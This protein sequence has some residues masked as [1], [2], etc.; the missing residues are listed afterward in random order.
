MLRI[1][2]GGKARLN[3]LRISQKVAQMEEK[4]KNKVYLLCPDTRCYTGYFGHHARQAG[5][6]GH[7]VG[8]AGHHAEY[9]GAAE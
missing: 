1:L 4:N 6:A 7:H 2:I 8:H 3:C 9:P 5:H